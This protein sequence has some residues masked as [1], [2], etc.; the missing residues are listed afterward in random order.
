[1][2]MIMIYQDSLDETLG[3]I[4]HRGLQDPDKWLTGGEKLTG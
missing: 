2:F 4:L 1:M 3:Y